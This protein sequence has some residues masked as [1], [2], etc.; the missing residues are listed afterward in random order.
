MVKLVASQL[1]IVRSVT[2]LTTGWHCCC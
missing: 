1:D 2:T